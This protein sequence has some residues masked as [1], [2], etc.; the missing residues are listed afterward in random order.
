MS[1]RRQ[2][3]PQPGTPSAQLSTLWDY[4]SQH[5]GGRQQGSARYAGATPSYVIW[6]LLC[7]YTKPG[8][9]IVDP[10]CGSGTTLDVAADLGRRARGFDLQPQRE[11]IEW[12]DARELPLPDASVDFFF[13]D[14]PYSQNL[15]YSEDERCIGTLSAFDEPYFESLDT[16][17]FEAS[18]VL[19]PGHYGAIYICDV[20][21]PKRGFAP[22]GTRCLALLLQYFEPIDHVCV[23]RHNKSLKDPRYR[24]GAEEGGFF[25]RG[26]NHLLIFRAPSASAN[27]AG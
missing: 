25:L 6:E 24:R 17:F 9:F 7:R 14:P 12:G 5:Y 11:D 10:M 15:K 4:P 19:K 16:V 18:R 2:G 20:H 8:D 22:I 26:F 3:G 23:V 1:P 21:Q 13:A 27:R